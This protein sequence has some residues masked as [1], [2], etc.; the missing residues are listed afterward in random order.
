MNKCNVSLLWI[1]D[2][3]K[4]R[5]IIQFLKFF[6]MCV[7]VCVCVPVWVH[8]YKVLVEARRGH[9]TTR[10]WSCMKL[11]ATVWTLGPELWFSARTVSAL[12]FWASSSTFFKK[13]KIQQ[14]YNFIFILQN[15]IRNFKSLLS[16]R[17][18]KRDKTSQPH[19]FKCLNVKIEV[20]ADGETGC[21]FSALSHFKKR[22]IIETCPCSW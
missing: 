19:H 18:I 3:K 22:V 21:N 11:W 20:V 15:V 13:I 14:F 10:N 2:G 8:V 6:F 5:Y 7:Y 12:N 17:E 1:L 9:W 16:F 4:N